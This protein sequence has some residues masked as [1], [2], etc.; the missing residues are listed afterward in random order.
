MRGGS[1]DILTHDDIYHYWQKET[2]LR[3]LLRT[4]LVL[5][6]REVLPVMTVIKYGRGCYPIT[7]H[8][9]TASSGYPVWGEVSCI[10]VPREAIFVLSGDQANPLMERPESLPWPV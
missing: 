7:S 5:V 6:K 1:G 4:I 8:T 10:P 3:T 2:V 9:L